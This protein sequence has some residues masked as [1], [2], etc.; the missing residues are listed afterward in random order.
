[1]I[2]ESGQIFYKTGREIF[3]T[4]CAKY[5][6]YISILFDLVCVWFSALGQSVLYLFK[7]LPLHSWRPSLS[8]LGFLRQWLLCP[9]E[10][11]EHLFSAFILESLNWNVD[12]SSMSMIVLDVEFHKTAALMVAEAYILHTGKSR[13]YLQGKPIQF[14]SWC[15]K[16]MHL[17]KFYTVQGYF[18]CISQANV[19]D[20]L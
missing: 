2:P 17:L 20:F 7:T 12:N 4:I 5:P 11:T 10:S 1:M 15:W 9:L 6:A 18:D 13:G 19:I 3:E 8:I 14:I 16:V